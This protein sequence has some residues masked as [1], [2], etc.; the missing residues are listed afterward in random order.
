MN[1]GDVICTFRK[2]GNLDV[3]DAKRFLTVG[4]WN[5]STSTKTDYKN[6]LSIS[7]VDNT[8]PK[9]RK[10]YEGGVFYFSKDG[11]GFVVDLGDMLVVLICGCIKIILFRG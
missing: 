1:M 10:D 8:N 7:R 9:P 11:R 3:T 4:Y 5:L 6:E 2:S